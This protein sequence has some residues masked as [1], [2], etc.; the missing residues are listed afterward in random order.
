MSYVD[1]NRIDTET[2]AVDEVLPE[3]NAASD[4]HTDQDPDSALE[5]TP[6]IGLDRVSP[7]QNE[8]YTDGESRGV[9]TERGS[10]SKG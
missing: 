10:D 7:G 9:M 2:N 1:P 3:K 6:D 8:T 4:P 5:T